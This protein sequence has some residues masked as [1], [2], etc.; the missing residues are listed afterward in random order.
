MLLFGR[1]ES[2]LIWDVYGLATCFT[3]SAIYLYLAM[4]PDL[5]LVRDRLSGA[6][7]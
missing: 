4:I 1:W 6:L 2:P 5:A 3:A 7:S